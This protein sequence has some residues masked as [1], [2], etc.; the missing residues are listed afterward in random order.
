MIKIVLA[1]L[2]LGNKKFAKQADI[3]GGSGNMY[4]G[5]VFYVYNYNPW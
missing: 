5:K 3:K 4:D 2:L 1:N